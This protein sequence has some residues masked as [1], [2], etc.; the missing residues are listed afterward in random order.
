VWIESLFS[1]R[2]ETP[3]R[4]VSTETFAI[5]GTNP[6]EAYRESA[7]RRSSRYLAPAQLLGAFTVC[8]VTAQLDLPPSP[9][10][11]EL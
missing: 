3:G 4:G 5:F 7:R 8:A 6:L 9:E 11:G 10:V 2:V 1:I